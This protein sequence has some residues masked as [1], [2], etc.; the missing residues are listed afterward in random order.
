MVAV[1]LP[2]I[3]FPLLV[4]DVLTARYHSFSRCHHR[5]APC[6]DYD[7][8]AIAQVGEVT[9][10]L[11]RELVDEWVTVTEEEI[12]RAVLFLLEGEKTVSEGAGAAGELCYT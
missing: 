12:C 8:S 6:D 1:S 11:C 10:E 3:W 2:L 9:R 4:S 5:Y 7:P